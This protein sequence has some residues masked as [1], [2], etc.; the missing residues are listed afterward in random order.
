MGF[1]AFSEKLTC[2]YLAKLLTFDIL[3]SGQKV[4]FVG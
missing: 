2:F 4:P 3:M 1:Y